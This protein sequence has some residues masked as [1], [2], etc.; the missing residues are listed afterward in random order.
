MRR[1]VTRTD[2]V[3]VART[4]AVDFMA[5]GVA[6]VASTSAVT[7]REAEDGHCGHASGA[8]NDAENVEVH[9]STHGSLGLASAKC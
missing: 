9:L 4:D 2:C 5:G 6:A 3:G 8:K 7:A 1:G